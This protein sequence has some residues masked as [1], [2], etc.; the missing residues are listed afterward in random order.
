[1][2]V[3]KY[4]LLPSMINKLIQ[5]FKTKAYLHPRLTQKPWICCTQRPPMMEEIIISNFSHMTIVELR[6]TMK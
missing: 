3:G 5:E 4:R 6:F 1:M 2:N